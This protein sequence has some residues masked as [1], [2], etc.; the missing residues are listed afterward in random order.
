MHDLR[1]LEYI[2]VYNYID[3]DYW[4]PIDNPAAPNKKDRQVMYPN[5]G[6]A[7]WFDLNVRCV[8]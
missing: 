1:Q 2:F 6:E 5:K 3:D 4:G 8:R 7:E